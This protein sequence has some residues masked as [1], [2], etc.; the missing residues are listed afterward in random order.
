VTVTCPDGH[1]QSGSTSARLSS[2]LE[3]TDTVEEFMLL[4]CEEYCGGP[5]GQDE[6]LC[7]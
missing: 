3:D 6:F 4:I 5:E 2:F 1:T 7:C